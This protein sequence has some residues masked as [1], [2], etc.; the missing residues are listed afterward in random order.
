MRTDRCTQRRR[1]RA[2]EHAV[3]SPPTIVLEAPADDELDLGGTVGASHRLAVA[4]AVPLGSTC[5]PTT[6]DVCDTAMTEF[7]QVL[8]CEPCARLIVGPDAA[9]RLAAHGA[10]N[11]DDRHALGEPLELAPRQARTDEDERLAAVV[12]QRLRGAS[13]RRV[14]ATG[15]SIRS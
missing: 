7:D 10:S 1:S 9:D 2:V 12:E 8:D 6:M 14:G 15:L 5:H 11:G 3:R 13:F 4:G